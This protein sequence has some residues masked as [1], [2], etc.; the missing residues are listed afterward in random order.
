MKKY[1]KEGLGLMKVYGVKRTPISKIHD[2]GK[3]TEDGIIIVVKDDKDS[4]VWLPSAFTHLI[5]H[6]HNDASINTKRKTKFLFYSCNRSCEAFCTVPEIN[7]LKH[8][9]VIIVYITD[10]LSASGTIF[11]FCT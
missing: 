11:S 10:I 6:L 7:V 3:T 1:S 9:V 2:Y 8:Y 5:R 4:S